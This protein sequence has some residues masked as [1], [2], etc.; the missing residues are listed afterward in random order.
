MDNEA[1]ALAVLEFWFG[2]IPSNKFGL[3]ELIKT[4]SRYPYWYGKAFSWLDVD[5]DVALK[6]KDLVQRA[7]HG[8]L[9]DW[10]LTRNGRLAL[11]LLLD[12]FPRN[13]YRN[14]ADAFESDVQ[15]HELAEF[16]IAQ[17]DDKKVNS[18]VRTFYYFPLMHQEDA[19]VQKRSVGLYRSNILD[20]DFL[21]VC[22]VFGVYL[23]SLR[24]NHIIKKFGRY[25]HRNSILGRETTEQERAFLKK[26]FSSF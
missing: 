3:K 15:A 5:D 11:I 1:E 13:I 10:K 20:A 8:E 22:N 14:T 6:F 23:S 18:L 4:C 21:N 2:L 25:P 26:P 9:D 24:H 19:S 12:Q 17:G 7:R 16:A